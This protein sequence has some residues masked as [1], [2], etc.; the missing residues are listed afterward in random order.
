MKI[1]TAPLSTLPGLLVLATLALA[2]AGCGGDDSDCV[3]AAKKIC[4]AACSCGGNSAIRF[5]NES[6]CVSLYSSG[7]SSPQATIDFDAC[8]QALGSPACVQST[9]GMALDLPPACESDE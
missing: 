2:A 4:A 8:V 7:C 1:I 3:K 5:D 6:G 9:D